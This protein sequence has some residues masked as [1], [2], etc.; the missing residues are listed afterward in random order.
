MDNVFLRLFALQI[1]HT[2]MTQINVLVTLG[3]IK[4]QIIQLIASR[5]LFVIVPLQTGFILQ[6][7]VYVKQIQVVGFI[8]LILI[9]QL[10]VL[11]TKKYN[12]VIDIPN[13]VLAPTVV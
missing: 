4:I 2:I 11:L 10:N 13:I 5:K 6:M 9:T 8:Q 1:K 7:S 12:V 3:I